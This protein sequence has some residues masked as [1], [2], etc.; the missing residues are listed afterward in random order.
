MRLRVRRLRL[1]HLSVAFERRVRVA[2]LFGQSGSP[3]Q[4]LY[5]QVLGFLKPPELETG[6][7]HALAFLLPRKQHLL[8][9]AEIESLLD[10][11]LCVAKQPRG[12]RERRRV[13]LD[14]PGIEPE[15]SETF[16]ERGV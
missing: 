3:E 9:P 11:A 8:L 13:R 16:S 6:D 5:V 7:D 10:L 4:R 14:Q 12:A 1:E 15:R 2:Q